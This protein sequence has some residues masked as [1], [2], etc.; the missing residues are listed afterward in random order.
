M[1]TISKLAVTLMCILPDAQS[2][3]WWP[4]QLHNKQQDCINVA[5]NLAIMHKG[6]GI[7]FGREVPNLQKVSVDKT[8]TPPILATKNLWPPITETPY[9]LYRLKLYWN[10]SFWTK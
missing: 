8:V 7:F 2:K 9:P 6:A 10:Q 1:R 3:F 5:V 4:A